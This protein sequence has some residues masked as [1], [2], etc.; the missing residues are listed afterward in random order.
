M[1]GIGNRISNA[2]TFKINNNMSYERKY[3]LADPTRPWMF[4]G[5]V[6][7]RNNDL[8]AVAN[9]VSSNNSLIN[10]KPY[11]NLA[12]G[13]FDHTVNKWNMVPVINS[14]E[15]LPVKDE[16]MKDDYNFGDFL[17]IR[18]HMPSKDGYLWDAGGYVI[19]G[20]NY[21]DVEPYFFMMR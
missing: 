17:T 21:Y 15:S 2:A 11:L 9:Y 16:K 18:P 8:G 4:G 3:Y 19:V 7:N 5:A 14:S 13:I 20:K 12:F 1:A 6:Q 10:T